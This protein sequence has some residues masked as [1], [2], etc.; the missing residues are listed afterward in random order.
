MGQYHDCLNIKTNEQGGNWGGHAISWG[1]FFLVLPPLVT[2]YAFFI[3]ITHSG[4]GTRNQTGMP[5]VPLVKAP[6][7]K[8]GP[9]VLPTAP[10]LVCGDGVNIGQIWLLTVHMVF[11]RKESHFT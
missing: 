6:N 11:V 2:S 7:P 3:C 4:A 10:A 5:E 9:C 1:G 8:F